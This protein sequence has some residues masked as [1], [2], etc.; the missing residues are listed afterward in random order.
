[1]GY[2]DP[3]VVKVFTD[4]WPPLRKDGVYSADE[5]EALGRGEGKPAGERRPS[6]TTD[7]GLELPDGYRA[8]DVGNAARLLMQAGG[9]LHYVH[10]WGKWVVYQRGRWTLDENDALVTEQGKR[11]AIALFALAAKATDKDERKAIWSWA[12]RSEASGSIAAMVRLTRGIPGVL[13]E[14]EDLDAD[15]YLLNVRNGTIDLRTGQLRPHDPTDLIT[16]QCPVSYDPDAK[17]PLWEACVQRWQPDPE[18]RD[19]IQVRAGAG[20]TGK[21]TETVDVDYG[22]G[23]NG[24]SK[25]WGSDPTRSRGLRGRPPQ[26]PARGAKA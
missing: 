12:L 10:A 25:F 18:V 23:S 1:M 2:V 7:T 14:H 4:D 3:G 20:T 22:S 26:E 6:A 5:L 19:Y 24:K 16:V 15:P 21:P 8:T 17:A 11:V 9:R 13:V